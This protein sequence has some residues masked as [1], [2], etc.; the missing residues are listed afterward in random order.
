VSTGS[1]IQSGGRTFH[2]TRVGAHQPFTIGVGG[3]RLYDYSTASG[4]SSPGSFYYSR[5]PEYVHTERYYTSQ[6][7]TTYYTHHQTTPVHYSYSTGVPDESGEY[8]TE[9]RTLSSGS[10][11]LFP[12]YSSVSL[13]GGYSYSTGNT[14]HFDTESFEVDSPLFKRETEVEADEEAI[15]ENEE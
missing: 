1:S 9:Y 8:R 5:E 15:V 2:Q 12:G 11:Q 6:A 3:Q 4:F 14:R 10:S 7:P 13:P